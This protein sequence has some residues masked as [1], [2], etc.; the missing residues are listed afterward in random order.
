VRGPCPA[1]AQA[2]FDLLRSPHIDKASRDQL[3]IR[4][5]MR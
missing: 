5:H 4:T 3:E 2:G 1:D